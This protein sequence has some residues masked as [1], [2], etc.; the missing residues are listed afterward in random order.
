MTSVLKQWNTTHFG[1]H[2]VYRLEECHV[3]NVLRSIALGLEISREKLCG[4]LIDL[5][6]RSEAKIIPSL[7]PPKVVL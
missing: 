7:S 4:D 2:C 5:A 1:E 6:G 3:G